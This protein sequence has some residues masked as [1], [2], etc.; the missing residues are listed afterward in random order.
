M[1]RSDLLLIGDCG[2][3][4]SDQ[5]RI[6][7]R[8]SAY[9]ATTPVDFFLLKTGNNAYPDGT[10]DQFDAKLFGYYRELLAGPFTLWPSLGNHECMTRLAAPYRG[11]FVLPRQALNDSDQERDHSFDWGPLGVVVLDSELGLLQIQYDCDDDKADGLAAD[12]AATDKLWEIAVWHRPILTGNP[13][14]EQIFRPARSLSRSLRHTA[15]VFNRQAPCYERFAPLRGGESTPVADGG[16]AQIPTGSGGR[17]LYLIDK[18]GHGE[19][20][21]WAY[22][23]PSL[24]ARRHPR[25]RSLDRGGRC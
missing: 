7:E 13:G 14:P 15:L 25:L 17:R 6:A 9:A 24:P 10:H 18:A 1:L 5:V 19:A 23:Y 3:A 4:T 16:I 12:L 2:D 20:V 21:A 11:H 22:P 8:T